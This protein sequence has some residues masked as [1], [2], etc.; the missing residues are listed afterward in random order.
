[1]TVGRIAI[2][3]LILLCGCDHTTAPSKTA[4][5]YVD[6]WTEMGM[7]LPDKEQVAYFHSNLDATR[8]QLIAALS[9]ANADVRQRAAYV[10]G[11][12][13]P[14]ARSLGPDLFSRLQAERER[15]IRIYLINALAA[16]KSDDAE[17]IS[18]LKSRFE[19][20]D[21]TNVPPALD[22]EYSDADEKIN[23]AA[24]LYVLEQS[25][26]RGHYLTFVLRW[27][28]PPPARLGGDELKGYWER[29]WVAVISL[30]YMLGATDAIP[31][32]EAMRDEENAKPWVAF[33]VPRVLDA[34]RA[35]RVP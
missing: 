22:H 34:L 9:H 3:L 2:V 17:V 28:Q 14:D 31:L 30:E 15:L 20:L 5:K 24:A 32:L 18:D 35:S 11:E 6:S 29:R 27:L 10:I 19:S 33:H 7:W 23:V 4:Q 25:Q 1:M 26:N 12:I 21:D 13:G 16:V 8:D